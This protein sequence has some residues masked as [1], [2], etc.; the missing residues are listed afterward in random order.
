ME[1]SMLWSTNLANSFGLLSFPAPVYQAQTSAGEKNV[2]DV[3]APGA[4]KGGAQPGPQHP[5]ADGK[6]GQSQRDYHPMKPT[7]RMSALIDPPALRCE[8]HY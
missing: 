7:R 4:N 8:P 6:V 5:A 3:E 2:S 1:V